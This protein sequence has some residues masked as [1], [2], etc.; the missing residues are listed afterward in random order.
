MADWRGERIARIRELI[1]EVAPG[2]TEEWKWNTPVW[3]RNGMVCAAGAF[4]DHVK[5]NFF[6]GGFPCRPERPL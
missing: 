6:K 1:K 4:K 2:V 5:I 3:S